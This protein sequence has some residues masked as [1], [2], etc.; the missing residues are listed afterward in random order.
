M[1]PKVPS[2]A[3]DVPDLAA[4]AGGE[5]AKVKE[6]PMRLGSKHS[7]D[8]A[9]AGTKDII[10][11]ETEKRNKEAAR[12]TVRLA[13]KVRDAEIP[14][15]MKHYIIIQQ[16]DDEEIDRMISAWK[17]D[18]VVRCGAQQWGEEDPKRGG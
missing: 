2:P 12:R 9:N 1:K 5:P 17:Q 13:G 15:S 10:D 3:D 7:P 4:S 18:R 14:E 8:F 16:P 6:M 11:D